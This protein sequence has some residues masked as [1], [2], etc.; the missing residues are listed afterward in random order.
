MDLDAG[1]CLVWTAM[2][3]SVSGTGTDRPSAVVESR[4]RL[5]TQLVCHSN[6][7][8]LHYDVGPHALAFPIPLRACNKLTLC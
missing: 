7:R 4:A 3:T 6:Q 2:T 8:L 1:G 5:C